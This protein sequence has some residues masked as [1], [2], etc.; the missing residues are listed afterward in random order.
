MHCLK[1][2]FEL[3]AFDNVK[4]QTNGHKNVNFC[5]IPVSSSKIL[6]I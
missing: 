4:Q 5:L 1:Q 6:P 3:G 2:C